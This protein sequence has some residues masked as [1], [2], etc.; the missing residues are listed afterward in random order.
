MKKIKYLAT[1]FILTFAMMMGVS[2]ASGSISASTSSRTVSV[3]STFTVTVKVSCSEALGSWQFGISYDSANISLQSGDTAI[4]AYGDGS[5]KSKSYTYKFKAIKSGS[6]AVRVTGA[7]MVTWNDVNTLF[8]PST[9]NASVT[10]KTQ[11]EI[12][13]SYSKDNNLKSLSVEGYE[14]SPAFDKNT[15]EYT[16]EVPYDV[17]NITVKAS[18]NDSKASVSGTGS[19][20][21]SEGTNKIEIVVTAQNGSIKTY[22]LTINVKDLNPISTTVDGV[23][24]TVVKKKDLLTCPTGYKEN[25]IK[26]NEIDVPV[27]TSKLTKFTVLGLKDETGNIGMFI[28]D[29][30]KNEYTKYNEIKGVNLTLYP[31]VTE[32][33]LDGFKASKIKINEV[34]YDCFINETDNSFILLYAMNVETGK[35]GYYQYDKDENTFIRYNS[36]LYDIYK[37]SADEFKLFTIVLGA[38]SATLLLL[39]IILGAK[40]SKL[41]KLILKVTSKQTPLEETNIEEPVQEEDPIEETEQIPEETTTLESEDIQES[42]LEETVTAENILDEVDEIQTKKKK[43][44]KR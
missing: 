30:D 43:K 31:Q 17:T 37:E 32:T 35:T 19:I 20:D 13:A 2:A 10:V 3:G 39:S 16:V 9:S 40:N 11:A 6:A 15:T 12:E 34:E 18:E 24:Y 42:I 5:T 22:Y 23:N 25:T 29:A 38:T 36:K 33:T 26:I 27:F 41:K 7:S 4:A 44:H 1:A 21:I 8:T 14:I 28:Y